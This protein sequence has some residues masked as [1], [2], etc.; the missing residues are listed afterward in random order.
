MK[1]R[2]I[3]LLRPIF[4]KNDGFHFFHG[5]YIE[6]I[7]REKK[8]G[9]YKEG[10]V[11]LICHSDL[12]KSFVFFIKKKEFIFLWSCSEHLKEKKTQVLIEK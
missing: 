10:T 8:N 1:L 5:L 6:L 4:K 9:I 3:Y 12:R 7:I 11:W 2:Y